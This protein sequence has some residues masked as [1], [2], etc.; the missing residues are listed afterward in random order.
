MPFNDLTPRDESARAE[1]EAVARRVIASG[2]YIFGPELEAFEREFAESVDCAHGVGVS[3]GTEAIQLALTALGVGPGDDVVTVA[4]T[5]VPTVSAI[6]AAGAQPVFADVD[7]ETLLMDATKVAPR[8]TP[9][10]RAIVPVHLFGQAVDMDPIIDLARRRGIPILED[11]AQAH[12][13]RFKGRPVGALGDACAWSFYPT[14]NL[15]ALGDAG[16]VT[17]NDAAVA[18]RLRRLRAYGQ[19]SRYVHV[20]K[21][22]NSRL[23]EIQAAFLRA[24]LPRL[25]SANT[26]RREIA[27]LYDRHL[28]GVTLPTRASERDHV[29]HLYV[30]RA[31]RRDALQAALRDE[32]IGTLI[33][34]PIPVHR[35]AAYVEHIDQAPFLAVTERAA[36]E[37]LSLPLYPELSDADVRRVADAVTRIAARA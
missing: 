31:A 1:L 24:K 27:A 36:D 25:S 33:H 28:H 37:I 34:Y 17:T 5:A 32:G 26:R 3:S 22:I 4:N 21:G 18:A 16:M 35:Q 29:F 11:A 30:I 10:T 23:D 7:P 8:I 9:R 19:S 13:A 15:G 14:K 2:W 12:G 20:E 6:T